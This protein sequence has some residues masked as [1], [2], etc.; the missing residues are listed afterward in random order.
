MARQAEATA[1]RAAG[2]W[3]ILALLSLSSFA[4]FYNNLVVGPLLVELSQSLGVSVGQAGQLVAVYA[5]PSAFVALLSGPILDRYGR[6]R[7]LVAST[8]LVAMATAGCALAADF[9]TMLACRLL[10]GIGGACIWPAT[11][12]AA[13]DLFTYRE[14]AGAI[15]WIMSASMLA[16]T[17]G[18]PAG[19]L[20]AEFLGWRAA[21][22]VV[23]GLLLAADLALLARLPSSGVARSSAGFYLVGYRE[24]LGHRD[25]VGMVSFGLVS[26]VFWHGFLT[27][28]GTFYQSTYDLSVGQLAPILSAVGFAVMLG[29]LVGGRAADRFGGKRVTVVC[30]LAVA[31]SL[32]VQ[33]SAPL[34]L[35]AAV[36]LHLA[37][38]IPNGARGPGANALLTEVFPER[39][40]TVVAL[41]S[42][43]SSL[44]TL[45][46]ASLGGVV[47]GTG[48]SFAGLG[49][50][51]SAFAVASASVL[52]VLVAEARGERPSRVSSP[53]RG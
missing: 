8:G 47:V 18:V 36:A 1:G 28:A 25:A 20:V 22:G 32:F 52:H 34:P 19:T 49:A 9:P 5:L 40:G 4:V 16:P 24:V 43:A 41:N 6:R 13:G 33:L 26:H 45:L 23:A 48:G 31:A 21:F 3:T 17:V 11:L 14:R 42:A 53:P 15:G 27:Y 39:R 35:L 51:C 37:W 46:G 2:R 7:V 30:L 38:S 12:A 10:A 44:G 29:N 50:L